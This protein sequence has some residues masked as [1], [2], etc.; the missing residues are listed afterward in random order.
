MTKFILRRLLL[1]ALTLWVVTTLIFFG[2]ALLPGDIAT[3]MMGQAASPEVLTA[4]RQE[5]GLDQPLWYRY[6][7][8][9][10]A[11]L[12]GDFGTSLANGR[13]INAL[14][15]GRLW[16]TFQLAGAAAIIAVPLAMGLGIASALTQGSLLD[17][18]VNFIALSLVSFPEFFIA[19]VLILI[20]SVELGWFPSLSQMP[21]D[22][23]LLELIKIILLPALTLT[24]AVQAH[25]MRMSRAALLG[26]LNSAYIEMAVLKGVRPRR[27]VL[28]HAL[29]NALA[30]I[31]N[32]VVLNMAW[33]IVGVVVVEVVFIY[34]GMGQLMVDSVQKR[35]LPVVQACSLAFAASYVVLN[36]TA[37][38]L[39]TLANPR[40][41]HQG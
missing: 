29:P 20:F 22:I 8:W 41:Q 23:T 36:M 25:I 5:L 21:S 2:V 37:D 34:P 30:P 39:S 13:E 24:L 40:L 10:G 26:V 9:L 31:I 6:L 17:R 12:Q 15:G 32:V 38:I 16:N 19:Y 28:H 11:V 7:N 3:E 35:D 33:L 4:F 1:G 14:I 18:A 27:I